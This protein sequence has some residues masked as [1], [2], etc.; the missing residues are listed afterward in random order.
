MA[1]KDQLGIVVEDR[2][3]TES[4]HKPPPEQDGEGSD[5]VSTIMPEEISPQ[6]EEEN[7]MSLSSIP[8]A[9][10][11]RICHEID[12]FDPS[13]TTTAT[14]SAAREPDPALDNVN[15]NPHAG[16]DEH[17][18]GV[19]QEDINMGVHQTDVNAQTTG[20]PNKTNGVPDETSEAQTTVVQNET[21][22]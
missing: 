15:I 19:E 13:D 5:D 17:I 11:A 8:S 2:F 21:E 3:G 12:N 1:E 4:L 6:E 7:N 18:A 16:D 9:H 20:V 10:D 14:T 22:G